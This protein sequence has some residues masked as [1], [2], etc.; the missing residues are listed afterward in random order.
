VVNKS[1]TTTAPA[2]VTFELSFPACRNFSFFQ[3]LNGATDCAKEKPADSAGG[4]S[5]QSRR[6]TGPQYLNVARSA[7][8]FI[9]TIAK[10]VVKNPR[11]EPAG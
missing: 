6:W 3:R 8:S 1:F 4:L 10:I 11:R 9:L 2:G 7:L 5:N